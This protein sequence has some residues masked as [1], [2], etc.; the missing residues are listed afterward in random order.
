MTG[1][2]VA[3]NCLCFALVVV[4]ECRPFK[5]GWNFTLR[6]GPEVHCIDIY[7]FVFASAGINIVTDVAVC[8][9][10]LPIIAKLR[11]S[12]GKKLVLAT[13]FGFGAM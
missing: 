10:P 2:I 9:L 5:A 6:F 8:I 7:R 4:F 1:I 12:K 13:L 11:V 3:I